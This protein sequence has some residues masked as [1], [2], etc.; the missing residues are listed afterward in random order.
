MSFICYWYC[1]IYVNISLYVSIRFNFSTVNSLELSYSFEINSWNGAYLIK[2]WIILCGVMS[3]CTAFDYLNW[4]QS[5]HCYCSASLIVTLAFPVWYLWALHKYLIF[6]IADD[7]MQRHNE[8]NKRKNGKSHTKCN[9]DLY[10]RWQIFFHVIWNTRQDVSHLGSCMEE[11]H[12]QSGL[13]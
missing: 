6:S 9:S 12:W 13:A 11:W 2:N 7:S 8:G 4:S 1:G 5:V 10:K 3:D